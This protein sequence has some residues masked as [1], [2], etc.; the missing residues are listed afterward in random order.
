[1]QLKSLFAFAALAVVP[2]VS[3]PFQGSNTFNNCQVSVRDKSGTEVAHACITAGFSKNVGG[4][5]VSA[6][7]Q[8]RFLIKPRMEEAHEKDHSRDVV[9]DSAG[10]WGW[11]M[12]DYRWWGGPW[13][14]VLVV[15]KA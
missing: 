14:A 1:M 10:L 8:L 3:I 4:A 7:R 13:K 6:N 2:A 9:E 5:V 15:V 12:R 11:G